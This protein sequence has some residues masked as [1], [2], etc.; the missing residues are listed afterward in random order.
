M[1]YVVLNGGLGD[2]ERGDIPDDDAKEQNR[3]ERNE[4][5]ASR[6]RLTVHRV[7][8]VLAVQSAESERLLP[9]P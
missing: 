3:N 1:P 6:K 8:I 2:R 4:E 9:V 7:S 5:D